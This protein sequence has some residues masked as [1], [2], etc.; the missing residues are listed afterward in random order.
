MEG[1]LLVGVG[2]APWFFG[3]VHRL[4]DLY[5]SA[6]LC[7]FAILWIVRIMLE[8]RPIWNPCAL[9][10]GL[11]LMCLLAIVQSMPMPAN[12]VAVISPATAELREKLLPPNVEIIESGDEAISAFPPPATLSL[13]PWSTRHRAVR[14]AC[15]LFLFAAVRANLPS[16]ETFRRLA[17]L[18]VVNG[19][20][21]SLL[22]FAQWFSSDHHLIYWYFPTDGLV[23]GPFGGRNNFGYYINLSIGLGVGLLLGTRHFR[24]AADRS[25]QTAP[26]ILQDPAALWIG[27]A[28][29]VM[30]AAVCCSMSRGAMGSLLIAALAIAA[31]GWRQAGR[32]MNWSAGLVF[33]VLGV[34]L[35]T[36]LGASV[37]TQ[38]VATMWE[39]DSLDTRLPLWHRTLGLFVDFPVLGIGIGSLRWVEPL[40]RG[41]TVSTLYYYGFAHNDYLQALIE[42]GLIGLALFLALVFLAFRAGI[43]AFRRHQGTAEGSLA[44]GA[45]FGLFASAIHGTVDFGLYIPACTMLVITILCVCEQSA[46]SSPVS[47]DAVGPPPSAGNPWPRACRRWLLLLSRCL[48]S[49]M[50][51]GQS[52]RS[53]TVSRRLWWR[54]PIWTRRSRISKVRWPMT[55][56]I[57]VCTLP[58]GMR[59]GCDSK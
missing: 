48:C 12:V 4:A 13:I 11:A 45:L 34:A 41:P 57:R 31:L 53:A 50:R 22:G 8:R 51:G 56:A 38:R 1:L 29:I 26:N 20:A 37:L 15:L 43:R 6:G 49:R 42:S 58:P 5:L 27:S 30:S 17:I 18:A 24:T 19:V 39:T 28:L 7:A 35:A 21:M 46:E 25:D 9:T 44:I 33:I 3:S 36:W 47:A 32:F 16:P 52:E 54:R 40:T 23:F 59:I 2:T 14:L 55:R 10:V